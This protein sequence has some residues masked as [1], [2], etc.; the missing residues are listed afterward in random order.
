MTKRHRRS[1]SPLL[2]YHGDPKIKKALLAQLAAHRKAD[3]IVQGYG[4]WTD[5]KG[6]A[7]GCTIHSG[8]HADY[9]T[10]LGIPESIAYLEDAIFEWLP[11]EQ[12]RK[13]PERFSRAIKPGADLSLVA[14]RFMVWMLI[15]PAKGVIR[16]SGDPQWKVEAA[17]RGVAELW[18]R[19]IDCRTV[20]DEEWL[21]AESAARSAAESTARSARSAWSAARSA[22]ESAAWSAWSAAR[23]AAE[24][25]AR[26]AWSAA[27]ESAARSAWSAA[28][29]SAARS[30]RSA[31]A[32]S[33]AWQKMADK[34]I[35][36][37]RNEV[38]HPIC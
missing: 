27:A 22:A 8:K 26:S 21:A 7:V 36:L 10:I 6:C 38:A 33:A 16:F 24:S 20:A 28:A 14:A 5:G 31:A 17:I 34:L 32:E 25:T 11:V 19:V 18:Q 4:Y 23:S 29:E 15:D 30:A 1:K 9:E 3:Q 2:A 35:Q 37:L 12:A 13:W